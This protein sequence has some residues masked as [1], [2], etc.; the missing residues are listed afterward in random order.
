MY[1][2]YAHT[3]PDGEI[4]YIGKGTRK[5]IKNTA[6][7]NLH[8]NNIVA[9][10][11]FKSV[12]LA[13]FEDEKTALDE[14]ALLIQ[15]FRKFGK[16]VN[17]LDRGDINPMSNPDTAKKCA[18]TKR[19]MGQYTGKEISVYNSKYQERMKNPE[20][21]KKVSKNRKKANAVMLEKQNEKMRETVLQIRKLRFDGIKLKDLKKIFGLSEGNLSNI[22]N[23]KTYASIY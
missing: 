13:E 15:H 12:V 22:C 3:K 18:E 16:L 11:G 14:E 10:H 21:A 5:R 6:N 19:A 8:W 4:F 7:R 20:F 23:R 1:Y 9:K 17:I 2:V